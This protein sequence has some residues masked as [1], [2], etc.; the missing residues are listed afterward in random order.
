MKK[1][2]VFSILFLCG[3]A[4]ASSILDIGTD[5][6][7]RT[8]SV[9]KADYGLTG[10]QNYPLYYSQRALAH[11]GGKFSPNL[12]FMTQFQALG[13]AGSSACSTAATSSAAAAVVYIR[14]SPFNFFR[15]DAT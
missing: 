10:N 12:E 5:Y 13:V 7:L 14:G 2:V 9:T 6:R 4:Y 1:L 11:I 15:Q 8:I 3:S